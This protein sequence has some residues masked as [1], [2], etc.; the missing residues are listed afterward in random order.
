MKIGWLFGTILF[1]YI[2]IFTTAMRF[3]PD[4]DRRHIPHI[5]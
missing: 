4:P 1:F 2:Q 5:D 3:Y